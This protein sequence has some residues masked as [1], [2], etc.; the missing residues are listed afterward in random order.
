MNETSNEWAHMV[1]S[2]GNKAASHILSE[3]RKAA[4][5]AQ[6][7][8]EEA[9]QRTVPFDGTYDA[10]DR[11]S[12]MNAAVFA[13]TQ[14]DNA[15]TLYSAMASATQRMGNDHPDMD[16]MT[17]RLWLTHHLTAQLLATSPDSLSRVAAY[18]TRE[19]IM[20]GVAWS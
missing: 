4:R 18:A 7:D 16:G 11:L 13:A 8:L 10:P 9:T 6:V 5:A 1:W 2:T 14:A 12:I 19:I 15:L 3:L 17:L 20:D